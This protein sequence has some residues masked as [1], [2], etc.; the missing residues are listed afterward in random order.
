M[1]KDRGVGAGVG[2]YGE[3]WRGGLE[4][5]VMEKDRGVGWSKEL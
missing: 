4:L 3:E 5:G 1:K 2:S